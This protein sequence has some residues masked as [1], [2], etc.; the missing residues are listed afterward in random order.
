MWQRDCHLAVYETSVVGVVG[1][2]VKIML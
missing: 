2:Y 1:V